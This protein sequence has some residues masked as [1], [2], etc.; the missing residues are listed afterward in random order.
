MRQ[1]IFFPLFICCL[2][3]FGSPLFAVEAGNEANASLFAKALHESKEGDFV[4]ALERWDRFLLSAP[5]DAA[6]LSNRGNVR[7]ALGDSEGAILDQTSAIKILPSETDPYLNRGIAEETLGQWDD[8]INDYQWVLT[9]E[10]ENA[11]ALY[12]LGNVMAAQ[13]DWL[14]SKELFNQ[15]FLAKPDFVMARSSKAL[16]CYQLHQFDQA[17]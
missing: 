11:S 16:A 4:D 1:K 8:A 13:N 5:T 3:W 7:L 15:A 17:E 9:R 6:A 10:P 2:F 12:N 14:Q